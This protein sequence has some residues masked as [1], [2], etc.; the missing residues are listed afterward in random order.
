MILTPLS[1]TLIKISAVNDN[2]RCP[3]LT[4]VNTSVTSGQRRRGFWKQDISIYNEG[5]VP[6]LRKTASKKYPG[7]FHTSANLG[8]AESFWEVKPNGCDP[9][10]DDHGD[11]KHFFEWENYTKDSDVGKQKKK[12]LGQ[13]VSYAGEACARQHRIFYISIL[14]IGTKA[15]LFRWDRA[16]TIVTRAF[17]YRQNPRPL[18]QYLWRFSHADM[19]ERGFDSTVT[20]AIE[21]EIRLFESTVAQQVAF[22]KE[23]GPDDREELAEAIGNHYQENR[24]TKITVR[25]SSGSVAGEYLVSVPVRSPLSTSGR[26]GRGFWSTKIEEKEGNLEGEA[27]FLKDVWRID[28][29]G[30]MPEG[31]ILTDMAG[32]V[33][34]IPEVDCSGDCTVRPNCYR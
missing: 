11:E 24:V 23:Y 17:D 33:P 19:V 32:K 12:A 8:L 2:G 16:G 9:F 27:G 14:I 20:V 29:P 26:S 6:L 30:L 5:D 22:Q 21:S 1:L 3:G 13:A 25:D 4:F 34:N 18:C 28:L 15:R 31:S 10:C 7:V